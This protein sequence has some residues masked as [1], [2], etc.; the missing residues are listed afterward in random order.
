MKNIDP[1]IRWMVGNLHVGSSNLEVL[2]YIRRKI[3]KGTSK[4]LKKIAYQHA[5]A[6][7]HENQREYMAVMTG[8]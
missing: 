4:G 5:L 2:R 7:H 1:Q 6:A 8:V 3:K